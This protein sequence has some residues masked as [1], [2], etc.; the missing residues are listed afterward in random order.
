[1]EQ[2]I[3]QMLSATI[4]NVDYEVFGS[5][6]TGLASPLS[7][8]DI[9][10]HILS[11][12]KDPDSERGPSPHR[13][14][15]QKMIRKMLL[16]I[17][18]V[19]QRMSDFVLREPVLYA[20]YPLFRMIHG[21]TRLEIQI[22][23]SKTHTEAIQSV[24]NYLQEYPQLKTIY[25]VIKETLAVRMLDNP[26]MGGIGSYALLNMIVAAFKINNVSKKDSLGRCLVNFLRFYAQFD[27]KRYCLSVD[28]PS[29]HY[30]KDSFVVGNSA[31]RKQMED[32]I[33]SLVAIHDF[34]MLI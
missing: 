33:V 34:H 2:R 26:R 15:A 11:L 5:H 28:P 18:T 20:R 30:K 3:L 8:I 31:I 17:G 12:Q 6:R 9:G 16:K 25:L 10:F 13:P 24:E 22:V 27:T 1:M 23:S 7:D 4:K 19:T 29:K 14:E 32:D 21:P